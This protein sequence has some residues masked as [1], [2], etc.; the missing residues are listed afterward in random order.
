MGI[1]QVF[2]RAAKLAG[3]NP[4]HQ[5]RARTTLAEP[6]SA[7][8]K[9]ADLREAIK[10]LMNS[11]TQLA[12]GYLFASAHNQIIIRFRLKRLCGKPANSGSGFLGAFLF[13]Y[14]V[15]AS[16]DVLKKRAW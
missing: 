1:L 16:A 4:L 15:K 10:A 5:L 8:G 12:F 11:S 7:T 2:Y 3:K 14:A 9:T 6:H 13:S